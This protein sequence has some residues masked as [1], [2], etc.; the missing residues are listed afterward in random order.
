MSTNGDMNT[1][2]NLLE[3]PREQPALARQRHWRELWALAHAV[4]DQSF[5]QAEKERQTPTPP[6]KESH[7]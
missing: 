3:A 1:Q 6:P 2:P 5:A 7:V 4:V